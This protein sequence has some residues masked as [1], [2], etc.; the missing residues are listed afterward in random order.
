MDE[1]TPLGDLLEAMIQVGS[2][3]G[4]REEDNIRELRR[5][6]DTLGGILS[7]GM[8]VS[9]SDD[10]QEALIARTAVR[11]LINAWAR[12]ILRKSSSSPLLLRR[13]VA[14]SGLHS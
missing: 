8:W 7:V 2:V 11:V 12:R 14:C 5:A 13:Q 4:S 1:D 3:H 6:Q 9:L 10:D